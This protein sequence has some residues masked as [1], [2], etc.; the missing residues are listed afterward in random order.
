MPKRAESIHSQKEIL[1]EHVIFK[2]EL[3]R[4]KESIF[5]QKRVSESMFYLKKV[6]K[7]KRVKNIF[8]QKESLRQSKRAFS[9]KKIV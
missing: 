4:A 7:C 6:K 2:R 5:S 1:R 8:T 3:N 9:L